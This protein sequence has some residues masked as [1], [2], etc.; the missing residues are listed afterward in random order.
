MIS[1]VFIVPPYRKEY[2]RV[3]GLLTLKQRNSEEG[4]TLGSLRNDFGRKEAYER[5]RAESET[6]ASAC[7]RQKEL[8]AHWKLH[9]GY[10]VGRIMRA[11]NQQPMRRRL[12]YY[13]SLRLGRL[14]RV[15]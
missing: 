13:I 9:H 12:I 7:A 15:S 8:Y 5:W 4:S 2:Q 3:I 14:A 1:S 10:T 11:Q 6:P